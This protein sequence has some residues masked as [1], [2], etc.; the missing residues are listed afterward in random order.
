[1]FI[2]IGETNETISVNKQITNAAQGIG[3]GELARLAYGE[4]FVEYASA[5][6][7]LVTRYRFET[8]DVGSKTRAQ[9][10]DNPTA[11]YNAFR[12]YTVLLTIPISS[13]VEIN[14]YT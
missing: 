4:T 12:W 9:N 10:W 11:N 13:S 3:G 8:T 1:M 14:R 5:D 7:A 2:N 6:G